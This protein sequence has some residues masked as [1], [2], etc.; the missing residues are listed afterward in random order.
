ME[1]P[2]RLKV[3][4]RA[5]GGKTTSYQF[6]ILYGP[7]VFDVASTILLKS[8]LILNICQQGEERTMKGEV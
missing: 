7:F 1:V 3:A 5:N 6:Q 8:M 2:F 4:E